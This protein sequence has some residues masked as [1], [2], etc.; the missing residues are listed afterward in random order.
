M[1]TPDPA[2]QRHA[3]AFQHT[4]QNR[5]EVL[6]SE[7]CGC[8]FCF[9]TFGPSAVR[10]WYDEIDG[11]IVVHSEGQTARCP[12]CHLDGIIGSASGF[13]ITHDLL[14]ELSRYHD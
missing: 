12:H 1:S 5:A 14:E 7:V 2:E 6:A 10:E 13:P 11:R 8:Y 9:N 4:L 3:Q